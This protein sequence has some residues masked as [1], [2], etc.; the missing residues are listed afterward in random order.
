MRFFILFSLVLSFLL[1]VPALCVSLDGA[2]SSMAA[3]TYPRTTKLSSGSILACYT[4]FDGDENVLKTLLST[5]SGVTWSALGE[6]TRGVGDIDNCNVL[7]V[8]IRI[9][10]PSKTNLIIQN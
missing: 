7:Q 1:I 9:H 5:D 2:A 8:K 3:G 4:A 6:I 10:T